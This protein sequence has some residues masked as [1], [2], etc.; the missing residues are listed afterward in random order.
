MSDL[1]NI[2][3]QYD[4]DA[5]LFITVYRFDNPYWSTS[6]K[7]VAHYTM[8]ST[9]TADTLFARQLEFN[10]DTPIPPK[11]YH[12]KDLELDNEQ[13]Y[14]LGVMEQMQIYAFEDIPYGPY[15]K[16]YKKD[17]KRYSKQQEVKYKINVRPS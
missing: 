5:V 3:K 1:R 16:K 6:T 10:Y 11:E 4:A 9:K 17:Q 14:D 2:R 7:A 13:V 8:I 12:N 15:H